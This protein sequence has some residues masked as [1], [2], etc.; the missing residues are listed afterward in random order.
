MCFLWVEHVLAAILLISPNHHLP[1]LYGKRSPFIWYLSLVGL[2]H[3]PAALYPAAL[4]LSS[5]L[6]PLLLDASSPTDMTSP[7]VSSYLILP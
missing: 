3:K 5:T 6:H 1:F 2:P 7:G 4:V